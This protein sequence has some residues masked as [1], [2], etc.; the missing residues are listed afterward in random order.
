VPVARDVGNEIV[1]H[2]SGIVEN[3]AVHLPQ[4]DQ[5]PQSASKGVICN[6]RVG[7]S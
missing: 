4:R 3:A 7:P 6:D 2:A 5:D 1:E